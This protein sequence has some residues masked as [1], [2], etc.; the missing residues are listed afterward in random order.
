MVYVVVPQVQYNIPVI[1][2][3]EQEEINEEVKIG[4]TLK[5]D[6]DMGI[7]IKSVIAKDKKVNINIKTIKTR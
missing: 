5:E 6:K 2:V 4:V 7:K 3:R 1:I